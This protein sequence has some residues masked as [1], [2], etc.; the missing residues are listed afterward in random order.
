MS[1]NTFFVSNSLTGRLTESSLV[2]QSEEYTD[3][4]YE[5]SYESPIEAILSFETTSLVVPV[6]GFELD[7]R[8]TSLTLE[9]KNQLTTLIE[10]LANKN[11]ILEM[12][13]VDASNSSNLF[14]ENVKPGGITEYKISL[15]K[16]NDS[17]LYQVKMIFI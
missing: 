9:V 1:D 12:S 4:E 2:D 16:Q 6:C 5:G 13:I 14:S 10:L 11:P 17:E 3:Y 7:D 15:I 8:V